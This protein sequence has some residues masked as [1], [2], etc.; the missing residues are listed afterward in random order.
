MKVLIDTTIWSL[1]LRRKHPTP[2]EQRFIAELSELIGE[3]RAVLIGPVRQEVLSGIPDPRKFDLVRKH[4]ATFDDLPIEQADYEESARYF[5]TCRKK[6]VQ[7]SHI[8]F[9]ICAVAI[10]YA[11]PVFTTDK[12]FLNYSKHLNLELYK[13]GRGQVI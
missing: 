4:L 1:A 6:G 2:N 8:D 12:D 13:P 10:R 5:N 7:G 9:L 3:L 11:V